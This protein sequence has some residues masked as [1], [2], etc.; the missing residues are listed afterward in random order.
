M[1]KFWCAYF[2]TVF[3][4]KNKAWGEFGGF[5]VGWLGKA[6]LRENVGGP[7][8]CLGDECSKLKGQHTQRPWGQILPGVLEAALGGR[9]VLSGGREAAKN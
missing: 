4:V 7:C 5:Y 8:G 1:A 6:A 9:C 3:L 2:T